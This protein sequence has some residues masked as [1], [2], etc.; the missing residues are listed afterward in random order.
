[1]NI[2][3]S[4]NFEETTE[5]GEL[6]DWQKDNMFCAEQL[7]A[8]K[9]PVDKRLINLY[10]MMKARSLGHQFSFDNDILTNRKSKKV[11]K[12]LREARKI[13]YSK[14][15]TNLVEADSL[16][17]ENEAFSSEDISIFSKD[18]K[19]K[20]YEQEKSIDCREED[21]PERVRE[22]IQRSVN[23]PTGR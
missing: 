15:L 21:G 10:M 23:S 1:M 18:K 6:S 14:D 5:S 11:L 3:E 9:K 22:L 20:P 17:T 12:K 19:Q 13:R 4:S 2:R 8:S 7:T 16:K